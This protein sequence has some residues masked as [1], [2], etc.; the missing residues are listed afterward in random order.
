MNVYKIFVSFAVVTIIAIASAVFTISEMQ[1][2]AENT[3]RLYTHPFKVSNAISNIQTSIITMHRNMKDIVLT[4]NSLEMINI[5]E[6]IQKEESKVYDN[7][8]IIYKNYLGKKS[9]IDAA[10]SAFKN[11]KPMRQEVISLIQDHKIRKAIS[12]TKGKGANHIK[13]LYSQIDVLKQYAINKANEFYNL[14]IK[15]QGVKRVIIFFTITLLLSMIIVIYVVRSLLKISYANNKQLHLIDQNILT[16]KITLDKEILSISSAFALALRKHKEDLLHQKAE[17]FFT[18]KAQFNSFENN[19]YSGQDYKSE[20]QIEIN[21][22]KNWF[23]IEIFPQLDSNF[24]VE[25]F[26]I[27]LIDIGDKKKIEEVSITDKLTNLHNR[28]YFEMIFEKETKRAKRDKKTLGVIMLDIDYFKQYNDTYGHQEGDIALKSVA[29]ILLA[30]TNRSYDYAFRVGGEEFIIITHQ[31]D[32]K[33]LEEFAGMM[34]HEIESLKISHKKNE[35]SNYLTISAGV[36]EF[37]H[38]HLL[39]CDDMYKA[40]DELLYEAKKAGRNRFKSL[41]IE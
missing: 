22:E 24:D 35:A 16:A 20:V 26:D 31:K 33:S 25:Y 13:N 19:I 3:N 18:T 14:S 9:D 21:S 40:V 28:N 23:Y 34:L 30:H 41:A 39:N 37:N 11:W 1:N 15:H 27:F 32:L 4:Q 38:K 8:S 29:H 36:I 5:I 17:Y 2:L 7:F 12:I 6:S 10:Y